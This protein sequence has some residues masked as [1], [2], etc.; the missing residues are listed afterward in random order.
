M[1]MVRINALT[2]GG[3]HFGQGSFQAIS[4]DGLGGLALRGAFD[5]MQALLSKVKARH[6]DSEE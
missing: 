2:F 5:L 1:G 6:L 3:L 4:Q